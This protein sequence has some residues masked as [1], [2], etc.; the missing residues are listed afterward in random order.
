MTS[1]GSTVRGAFAFESFVLDP[2]RGSLAMN[3]DAIPLRPKSFE[4]L[5][6]L[7]ENSGRLVSKDEVM[8]AVWPRIAVTDDSLAKCIS[9]IRIALGDSE[10]RLIKTVPRRGYLMDI[11]V[12]EL[13]PA[14]VAAKAPVTVADRES[15]H[16]A[17]IMPPE[18]IGS[19]FVLLAAVV[20]LALSG[21]LGVRAFVMTPSSGP[22]GFMPTDRA[23]LAVLRFAN[24]GD[25]D[26]EYFSD[27]IAEDL[28][29]KLGKFSSLYVIGKNSAFTVN[30]AQVGDAEIG[31]K[32]GAR[33]LVEGSVRRDGDKVRITAELIDAATRRQLWADS[34]DRELTGIFAVQDAVTRE[35]VDRLVPQVTRAELDRSRSKA[36][37][38]LD[39]YDYY[40]Q[41]RTLIEG[42]RGEDRGAMAAE[43]RELFRKA[44]AADQ[45][46]APAV[47]GLGYSYAVAWLEPTRYEP[48]RRE[49][50]N[51]DV[52]DRAVTLARRA[53][54]LDPYLAGAHATLAWILHWQY[55]RGEA[56]AEF[57]RA[58]ELNPNLTDGR[59]GL[60]LAHDGRATE[61]VEFLTRAMHQDPF[62]P[63][64]YFSYL[65]NAYFLAGRYDDARRTL[66]SGIE[67][68]PDYRPLHLWLAAAAA[69]AGQEA[70]ARQAAARALELNPKFVLADW[71]HH[72]RL[73]NERDAERL[74]EGMR[75]AG[76]G[77][78][79][80][81][82][83]VSTETNI[84]GSSNRSP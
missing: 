76:L 28:T 14:D 19:Q 72:I 63:A 13:E 51:A 22:A 32:L 66:K 16:P 25:R 73:G 1:N 54:E 58:M 81:S 35:I 47:E 2:A 7:V 4:V 26:H 15:I 6:Y 68:L 39:A 55:Q 33:Y 43:A 80:V 45:Q 31:G 9:E 34:Y 27:G 36:P 67:R 42:R 53:V 40:L 69:L 62:P 44:V 70:E 30:G 77:E 5:L 79:A 65:G 18:R 10:Q 12:S 37:G 23:S 17:R 49:F 46:Y 41:G 60:M 11:P 82:R 48:Y 8:E 29:T 64:I 59:F 61:A 71:L 24:L 38:N 57:E 78:S 52:L 84:S 75:K 3:G 74:A 56:L 20:V 83:S 21:L 50:Q